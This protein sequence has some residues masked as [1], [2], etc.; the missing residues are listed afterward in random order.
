MGINADDCSSMMV[1]SQ[2][3]MPSLPLFTFILY[4]LALTPLA[5][6]LVSGPLL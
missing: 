5:N 4:A 3:T 2:K 1:P 6:P